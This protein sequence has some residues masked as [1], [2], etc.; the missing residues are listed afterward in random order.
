[1]FYTPP[2][3]GIRQPLLPSQFA[4][5]ALVDEPVLAG[6][7]RLLEGPIEA[8]DD[9]ERCEI[10]LRAI[11]LHESTSPLHGA[12]PN[13]LRVVI[14][15]F[16]PAL[17]FSG[18][19]PSIPEGLR[20]ALNAAL[21]MP[22]KYL[23]A[24]NAR[25]REEGTYR[26]LSDA[27]R[28]SG[29]GGTIKLIE[30]RPATFPAPAMDIVVQAGLEQML[31]ATRLIAASVGG[32]GIFMGAG[33]HETT[34]LDDMFSALDKWFDPIP[35][36]YAP[37]TGALLVLPPL[38]AVVLERARSRGDIVNAIVSVREELA[39][40]AKFFHE[41]RCALRQAKTREQQIELWEAMRALPE[42]MQLL[43]KLQS[44]SSVWLRNVAVEATAAL[45]SFAA[46]NTLGAL[47]SVIKA[48]NAAATTSPALNYDVVPSLADRLHRLARRVRLAD[49]AELL[50]RHLSHYEQAQLGLG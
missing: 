16:D 43:T 50:R 18:D 2:D 49:H 1:M 33:T 39:P 8:L 46:Q 40:R 5:H 24:S 14:E 12:I 13:P 6:L 15:P 19:D 35:E 45:V 48:G 42:K 9:L 10:G 21:Q 27:E 4:R 28:T 34:P 23:S 29:I 26:Y 41:A 36:S 47:V 7:Q 22:Q 17:E 38:L 25:S 3:S 11:L 37:K 20:Q 31:S 30:G 32:A 44:S